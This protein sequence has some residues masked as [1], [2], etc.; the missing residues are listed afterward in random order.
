MTDELLKQSG[1]GPDFPAGKAFV[2]VG[3]RAGA[4]VV[5]EGKHGGVGRRSRKERQR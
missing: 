2:T 4:T 3:R 1:I 5:S